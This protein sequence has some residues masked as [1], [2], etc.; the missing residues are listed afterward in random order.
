MQWDA[1]LYDNKH[2]FISAYGNELIGLLQPEAGQ[3]VL[4]LGCGTG[5]LS[6]VLA[7]AGCHVLGLDASAT[8]IDKAKEKYPDVQFTCQSAIDF[9]TDQ[10][11]DGVL[12][13]AVLHWIPEADQL[14]VLQNIR[15]HLTA[16]GRFVAEMGAS[17][18]VEKVRMA[19]S[20]VLRDKGWLKEA[21]ARIWYFPSEEKY[22]QLLKAAGFRI[23]QI[24]C[25]NRPT[26]LAE[27]GDGL[28][29]WLKMFGKG[30]FDSL[31][32]AAVSAII[33]EVERRLQPDLFKDNQWVAD[34]RRLRFVACAA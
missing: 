17:G 18:N 6:A 21:E 29:N 13:N 30:W 33:K 5:D 20:D 11:F 28:T 31:P 24:R 26:V 27:G 10:R 32:E 16:G 4:D 12:S 1:R 2:Q 15:A 25:F 7:K 23:E 34:Y 9:Q 14:A 19:V 22:Q 8:M 3:Q